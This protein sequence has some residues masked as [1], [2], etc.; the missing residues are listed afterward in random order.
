MKKR[1]MEAQI[2]FTLRQAASGTPVSEI[3]RKIGVTDVTFYP[4]R[5]S[6]PT[7]ASL[8]SGDSSSLKTTTAG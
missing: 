4:G 5:K 1:F 3:T 6:K 8:R 7:S 2:A